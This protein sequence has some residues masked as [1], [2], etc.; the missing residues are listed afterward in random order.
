MRVVGP[1]SED[2]MVAVFLRGELDSPRFAGAIRD[3]LARAGA[4]AGLV[5]SPDLADPGENA[6]RRRLLTETRAY[7]TRDG[8]FGGF[9]HDVRWQRVVLAREELADVR[10][11]DWSY[12]LELSGGSR[13]PVDAARRIH[14][15]VAPFG[16]PSDG[17]L[18]AA[19][20]VGGAWPE[21]LL[22]SAGEGGPV[23]VLEGHVRLTA[24]VLAGES[25]P[26]EIDALL[27]TSPRMVDWA[28]Y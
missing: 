9:P 16:V 15:G 26:D 21:L 10:Y 17:F 1:S 5:T 8:V 3:A 28:L 12:W 19:E 7:E 11:I 13:S 24:Y 14:E 4:D 20:H 23:V 2:E 22:A 27:G 25:A 18:A 6:L